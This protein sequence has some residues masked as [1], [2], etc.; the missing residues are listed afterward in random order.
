MSE[1][2]KLIFRGEVLDGQH[3][4]VVRRRLGE[5]A[6]FSAQHLEMLFSGRPVVVKRQVD[7]AAAARFQGLFKQAGAVLHAVADTAEDAPP[8]SAAPALSILPAGS[9]VLRDD[10]RSV[11]EPRH[12]DTAGLDLAEAG[13]TLAPPAEPAAA[14]VDVDAL[15]FEVAPPGAMLGG[16]TA[17]ATLQPPDVS[18]LSL[19]E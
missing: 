11:W 15:G 17:A 7:A 14:P 1:R 12:I 18:H 10:E 6:S 3:P 2:Y 4:A 13:A 19:V 16:G 9:P 5:S 8:R